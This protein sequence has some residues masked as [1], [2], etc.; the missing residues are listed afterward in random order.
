MWVVDKRRNDDPF[1]DNSRLRLRQVLPEDPSAGARRETRGWSI[2]L[3]TGDKRLIKVYGLIS[4]VGIVQFLVLT[5][6]AACFYPGGYDYFGYYFSDLGAVTARNGEPNTLSSTLFS[7]SL[8]GVAL[9]LIPFWISVRALSGESKLGRVLSKIGSVSGLLSTP[10][11]LGVVLYPMDTQLNAHILTT[12]LFFTFF[13]TGIVSYSAMFITSPEH[14]SSHGFMG[15]LLLFFSLPI[16]MDPLASYV[17]FLQKVL[18][19]GCF[20][21]VLLPLRL[22]SKSNA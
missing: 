22:L 18:A 21:W 20:I 5:F 7:F 9:S 1:L 17:A 15:L 11:I 12:M 19:Y 2:R 3:N 8:P 4:V 16:F 13:M 14:P 6:V 10:F